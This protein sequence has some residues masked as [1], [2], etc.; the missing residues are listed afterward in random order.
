MQTARAR[1]VA[2]DTR[3]LDALSKEREGGKG[4]FRAGNVHGAVHA[5]GNV[6]VAGFVVLLGAFV[7][8]AG[9]GSGNGFVSAIGIAIAISAVVYVV[10]T[11]AKHRLTTMVAGTAHIVSGTAPPTAATHGRCEMHLIV[12]AP[13]L[14]A[15]AV[16]HRDQSVPV[17]KWPTPGGSLPVLVDPGNPRELRIR[18]DRVTPHGQAA[19]ARSTNNHTANN[20]T[21]NNHTTNNHDDAGL[22]ILAEAS[23]VSVPVSAVAEA[24]APVS[25]A[26]ARQDVVPTPGPS[27]QPEPPVAVESL[28]GPAVSATDDTGTA[29]VPADVASETDDT[30][31]D[32]SFLDPPRIHSLAE[33][34]PLLVEYGSPIREIGVTLIVSDLQASLEFYRDLLG[35]FEI[36]SGPDMVLLEARTGRLVLRHREDSQAK[37]PRLMHLSL[38]VNDIDTAH[39]TLTKRGVEFMDEPRPVLRGEMLELWAV[40]FHDPDGHG[41]ALTSWLPREE[42]AESS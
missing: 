20:H 21:T 34:D 16:L 30:P 14:A 40:S 6:L 41:V 33:R 8:T 1:S 37:P 12:Q 15:T 3:T 7:F 29:L 24:T 18:W 36:E 17:A 31:L 10:F 27:A 26:V 13:R 23:G 39:R 42:D 5:R 25:P 19:T 35:F 2:K 9:S 11:I 28:A 22:T 4:S 38:E 32:L